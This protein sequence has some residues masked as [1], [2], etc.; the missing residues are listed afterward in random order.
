[1]LSGLVV[2]F[3]Q[4]THSLPFAHLMC[5]I[6]LDEPLLESL[7]NGTLFCFR[8]LLCQNIIHP[9]N[10]SADTLLVAGIVSLL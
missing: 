2:S 5:I 3:Y 9:L 6:E 8:A 10:Q 4:L 1:L 7:H